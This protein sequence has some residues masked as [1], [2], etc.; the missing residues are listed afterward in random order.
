M[1]KEFHMI[2]HIIIVLIE[3]TFLHFMQMHKEFHMINHVIIVYIK[4]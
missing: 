2:N 1:P 3:L 4:L